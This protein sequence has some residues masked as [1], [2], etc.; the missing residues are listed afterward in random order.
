MADEEKAIDSIF[1]QL[2]LPE[3]ADQMEQLLSMVD[4]LVETIPSYILRCNMEKE[5]VKVAY[6]AV[7]TL[8]ESTMRE[9]G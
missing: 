5:S 2:L 4:R 1:Q 3:R 8:H 9:D 7:K 6:N